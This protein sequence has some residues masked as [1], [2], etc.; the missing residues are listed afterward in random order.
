MKK[1]G[2]PISLDDFGTGFSSLTYLKMLP[3]HKL[4]I[5]KSFIDDVHTSHEDKALVEMI[6]QLAKLF[7]LSII[8]EGVEKEEQ[9][10]V[11]K[12]LGCDSIQ[13]HY[14]SRPERAEVLDVRYD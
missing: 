3:I 7:G 1:E 4:K 8:A 2:I 13:G 11:L 14:I 12:E 6:I 9:M 10:T 5:D